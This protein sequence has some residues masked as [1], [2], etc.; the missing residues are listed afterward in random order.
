MLILYRLNRFIT[1]YEG[2]LS[3]LKVRSFKQQ[4][5]VVQSV[6]KVIDLQINERK[7]I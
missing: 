5:I 6:L 1:K 3:V 4:S 2:Y 7:S